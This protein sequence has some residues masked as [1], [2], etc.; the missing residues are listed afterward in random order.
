MNAIICASD[1]DV[2]S[3]LQATEFKIKAY[4]KVNNTML[5]NGNAAI[6]E[7]NYW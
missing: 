5:K 2:T 7:T 1:A 3:S 6:G 4:S